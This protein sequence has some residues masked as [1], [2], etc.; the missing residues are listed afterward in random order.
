MKNQIFSPTTP[1]RYQSKQ[2]MNPTLRFSVSEE[3]LDNGMWSRLTVTYCRH[4]RTVH[5]P[6][7]VAPCLLAI[8]YGA[9]MLVAHS[10]EDL[11]LHSLTLNGRQR[12]TVEC[13]ERYSA[14]CISPDSRFLLTGGA[15]GIITLMWL[16]S[17]QVS[18]SILILLL[19]IFWPLYLPKRS[20]CITSSKGSV[21][22]K[23]WRSSL[24]R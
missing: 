21:S 18:L 19:E 12:K 10:V 16:H 20:Q 8:S 17:F 11:S 1:H 22:S 14:M 2:S 9:A 7:N 23:Q 24:N 3:V 6:G 4:V 13:T 15:K 5:L